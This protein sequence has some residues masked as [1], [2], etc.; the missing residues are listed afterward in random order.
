MLPEAES[1]YHRG[2]QPVHLKIKSLVVVISFPRLF[3][4]AHL[5]VSRVCDS[6]HT[7]SPCTCL[8]CL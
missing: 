1:K 3:D 5:S 2:E 6:V 4:E 7:G 8:Y